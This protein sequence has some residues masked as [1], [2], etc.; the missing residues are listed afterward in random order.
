MKNLANL[1]DIAVLADKSHTMRIVNDYENMQ[2]SKI[3]N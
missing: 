2:F 3:W 1:V